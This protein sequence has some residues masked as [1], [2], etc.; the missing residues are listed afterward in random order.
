MTTNAQTIA[1]TILNQIG[2][3]RRLSMMCGCKNFV[4]TGEGLQFAVGTN[5]KR[6]NRCVVTLGADD[7]YS[8]QF[9]RYSMRKL[10]FDVLAQHD[11]VYADQLRAL[12][13]RETGMYL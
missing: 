1:E 4:A 13:E 8:V 2:G 7:L 11:G 9:G 5:E 6:V 12:F 10:T 3:A